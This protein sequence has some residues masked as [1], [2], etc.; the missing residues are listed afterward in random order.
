V[1]SAG[2]L[3]GRVDHTDT[4][5]AALLAAANGQGHRRIA[6]ELE[7]PADTVHGWLRRFRTQADVLS[8]LAVSFVFRADPGFQ[9]PVP[10]RSPLAD[11]VAAG[12][13]SLRGAE[14]VVSA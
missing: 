2:Q 10:E 14:R 8:G 5:G 13:T 11:A 1:L 12:A 4:V 3:P 6:A 7:L 9:P